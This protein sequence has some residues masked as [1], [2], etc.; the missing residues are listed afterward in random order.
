[1]GTQM[2][3]STGIVHPAP[4]AEIVLFCGEPRANLPVYVALFADVNLSGG[5]W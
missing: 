1:M 5:K 2:K 4:Q 3:L